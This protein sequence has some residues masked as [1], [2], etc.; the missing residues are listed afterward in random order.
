LCKIQNNGCYIIRVFA[1]TLND[2]ITGCSKQRVSLSF[3]VSSL[4]VQ[5]Y[6]SFDLKAQ[7]LYGGTCRFESRRISRPL[8]VNNR[9]W[10]T[11][12]L[13]RMT[14]EGKCPP[15]RSTV[16]QIDLNNRRAF[17]LVIWLWNDRRLFTCCSTMTLGSLLT[18]RC[19]VCNQYS[20]I[21]IF[22][23]QIRHS[24]EWKK[25]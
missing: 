1:V 6:I 10:A 23:S 2:L 19:F 12:T 24:Y 22:L 4:H 25:L 16:R 7:S 5:L 13:R 9:S 14:A 18:S 11:S 8:S 15:K 20:R 17:T 21:S 3:T